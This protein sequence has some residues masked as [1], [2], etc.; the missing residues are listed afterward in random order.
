MTGTGSDHY[1][2][3]IIGAGLCGLNALFVAAEYLTPADRVLLVDRRARPGGMWVDV[4][5]Y[6]R[7]HQPHPMFTAGNIAWDWNRDPT[8]LAT[9]NEVLNHMQH[10]VDVIGKKVALDELY[11]WELESEA[12]LDDVVEVTLRDAAGERRT[13]TTTRL[14]KAVG[15]RVHPNDPLPLSSAR[16][17]SVSPDIADMQRA[18]MRSDNAPIWIIGSGKTAMDTAYSLIRDLPGRPVNMIAG[19]GTYFS[20]RAKLFPTGIKRWTGGLPLNKFAEEVNNRFDGTNEAEVHRW[21]RAAHGV[22]LTPET[23]NFFLG[24]LSRQEKDTITAGLGEVLMDHLVDAV[25]TDDTTE[26]FLRSGARRTIEPGSWVVNCTGYLLREDH[27]YEPYISPGG[28]VLS[29]QIRSVTLQ[30]PSFV[31]YYMTHLLFLGKLGELPL[32]ALDLQELK[33]K[34]PSV[35]PLA[36]IAVAVH[37]LSLI[38]ET[39]SP[40]VFRGCGLDFNQW[41]PL[42]RQLAGSMRFLRTHKQARAKAK[43]TLDTLHDR[44][45][46]RCGPLEAVTL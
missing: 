29:I 20:D 1:E 8:Y 7:L 35:I 9:K 6:V 25:D 36:L 21:L 10:C 44:F 14:I 32:Y 17:H 41:Y 30:L 3:V 46:I 18:A 23:G 16:V 13:I 22:W 34:A 45:D 4:Y 15:V 27:P 5:P 38:T 26:L 37:N 33:H 11:G 43:R 39:V 2:T 31:A 40:K 12:E 28:R 24:V 42:P 19:S